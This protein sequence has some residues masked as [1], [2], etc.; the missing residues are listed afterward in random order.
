MQPDWSRERKRFFEWAPSKT[1]IRSFRQYA[2][3]KNNP[4]IIVWPIKNYLKWK[5]R[6]LSILIGVDIHPDAKIA[7]GFVMPHPLGVV[8]HKSAVIGTNCM[9][10]QQVTIGQT[11][12][13]CDVPILGDNVYVGAGAKIIGKV[14]IGDGVSVG[15]NAVVVSDVPAGAT[16]VGIPARIII[17]CK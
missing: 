5:F 8:I 3:F 14:N 17:K 6:L 4:R 7:G 1:L 11:A 2:A 10:M 12:N 9:L 13:D 16:A 15:A